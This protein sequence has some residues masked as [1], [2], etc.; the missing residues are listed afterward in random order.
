MKQGTLRRRSKLE[1]AESKRR[2]ATE[3]MEIEQKVAQFD[4]LQQQINQLQAQAVQT[5]QINGV[6]QHLVGAGLIKELGPGQYE[7]VQSYEEHQHLAA[8]VQAESQAT[9]QEVQQEQVMQEEGGYL[10]SA[11]RIRPGMQLELQEDQRLNVQDFMAES[12]SEDR[13][14]SDLYAANNF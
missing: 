12:D 10:P 2:Q 4:A 3:K 6:I 14:K 5:G 9:L 1:I 8:Q 13:D 11:D 7:G